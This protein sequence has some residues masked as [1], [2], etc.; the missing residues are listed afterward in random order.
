MD[1]IV[2]ADNKDLVSPDAIFCPP[3]NT[4]SLHGSYEPC[5]EN[6]GVCIMKFGGPPCGSRACGILIGG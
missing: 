1:W 4:C 2:E 6:T 5:S 3:V